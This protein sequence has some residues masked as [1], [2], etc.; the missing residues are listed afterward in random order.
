MNRVEKK[1]IVPLEIC[2][3]HKAY[4]QSFWE[5]LQLI[6]NFKRAY[7]KLQIEAFAWILMNC[8]TAVNVYSNYSIILENRLVREV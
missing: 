8:N 5:G 3:T 4:L 6:E 7:T 2:K 1:K